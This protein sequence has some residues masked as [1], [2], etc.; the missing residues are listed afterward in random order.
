MSF[1]Y[2]DNGERKK[3]LASLK[4]VVV[5]VGSNVLRGNPGGQTQALVDQLVSLQARGIEVVLVTSGAIPLGMTILGKTTRPKDLAKVQGL[6]ALGQCYLMRHYENACEKHGMHCAQ[7]LLTAADLRDRER[8]MRVA[9]CIRALLDEG[10]LPIIN[11][12]DS[13][14]VAEIK[15]GDNDTLAAMVA[16]MLDADLTVLMTTIDAFHETDAKTGEFGRRFSVVT[17][18]DQEL[19]AMAGST[20]GNPYSTGGMMTKL[21]AASICTAD[22]HALAIVDGRDFQN[23]IRFMDGEDIGTLFCNAGNRNPLRSWQRF[24]T[25]FSEPAGAVVVDAGAEEALVQRNKSLLPGG[26]LGVSGIFR[27]G[28]P[29]QILNASRQEIA[30]GIANFSSEELVRVCGAKSAQLP[31]LL[32]H[33]VDSPEAVHKDFLVLK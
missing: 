30:R 26:V 2:T 7:L 6:S 4:R 20:D 1:L 32:G 28:D 21:H 22:G 8:N 33:P 12:N 13:V 14:S 16:T 9:A 15:I 17:G 29:I 24:L 27:R 19:L 11:E 18:L 3:T 25:F 23:L 31:E 5:K 10:I